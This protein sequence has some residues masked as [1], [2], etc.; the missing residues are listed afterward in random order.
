MKLSVDKVNWPDA[1]PYC[2]ETTVE[3]ENNHDFLFLK[4]H[5]KSEQLRAATVE[6]QG[7]V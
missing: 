7:P 5:I 2:P 3:I 6:D 1:F 4:Y